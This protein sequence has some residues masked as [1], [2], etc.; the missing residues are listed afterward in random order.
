M[1]VVYNGE[2]GRVCF[3]VLQSGTYLC[4]SWMLEPI[5]KDLLICWYNPIWEDWLFT[6]FQH[7]DPD[8]FYLCCHCTNTTMFWESSF[9]P[10]LVVVPLHPPSFSVLTH[11]LTIHCKQTASSAY[12]WV[13]ARAYVIIRQRKFVYCRECAKN[14]LLRLFIKGNFVNNVNFL[15]QT[16]SF[17]S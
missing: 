3:I 17:A 8:R 11:A 9:P 1:L 12:M 5:Y 10:R 14:R 4:L 2:W 6:E 15:A 13:S 7:S 16:N